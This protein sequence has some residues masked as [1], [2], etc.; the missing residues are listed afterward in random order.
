MTTPDQDQEM[1]NPFPAKQES[2]VR[3]P[4]LDG[5]LHRN[6]RI[7]VDC[8]PTNNYLFLLSRHA[9][10]AGTQ[11]YP[12][13]LCPDPLLSGKSSTGVQQHSCRNLPAECILCLTGDGMFRPS[14]F[15]MD[16]FSAEVKHISQEHI[17]Q[18]VMP[19]DRHRNIFPSSLRVV[20]W[21]GSNRMSPLSARLHSA[22]LAG[23][24]LR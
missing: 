4:A 16:M 7:I 11:E 12:L 1:A 9:S 13:F 17:K 21:Y 18:P 6:L 3:D 24:T 19:L 15:L 8:R 20:P 5:G 10:E 23:V 14:R 2:S 22:S